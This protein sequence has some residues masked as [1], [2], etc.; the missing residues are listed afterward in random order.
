M[1]ALERIVA[2]RDGGRLWTT[3]SGSGPAVIACHGG[4]GLWDYLGSLAELLED[5]FTIVRFDQRGCGR[6]SDAHTFT[7]EQ[8]VQ[9]LDAVRAAYDFGE[10][11][12]IGHSW[13]AELVL[14]Y[15]AR[16]PEHSRSIAYV[17]GVGSDDA[18]R[19]Y[20]RAE[21]ARRLGSELSRWEQLAAMRRTSAEEREFC[22]LQWRPDFAPTPRAPEHARAL[23]GTRP[24]GVAV[25][26]RANRELWN[27]RTSNDL[28]AQAR[29]VIAPV[30]MLFGSDDPRPWRTT[31]SVRE[32]LARA[33][34]DVEHLVLDGAGHAP[35]V[36]RPSLTRDAL[37]RTLAPR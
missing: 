35:W 17:A 28:L 2:T 12:L 7:I 24:Q 1:P 18:F 25:N 5:S 31:A 13:G 20:Y 23:W 14:R 36:E 11:G 32:E 6:S 33:G 37:R 21:F 26:V 15:A 29:D 34:V 3:V 8:A 16:Y 27:E 10:V 30:L 4:P 22:L 19:P 9:D